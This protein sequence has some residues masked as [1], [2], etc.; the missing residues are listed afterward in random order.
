MQPKVDEFMCGIDG[1]VSQECSERKAR[2]SDGFRGG[3]M[4]VDGE[5]SPAVLAVVAV[6][7]AAANAAAVASVSLKVLWGLLLRS[8]VG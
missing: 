3:G 5:S 1:R 8:Q 2:H 4:S 7:A 6:T